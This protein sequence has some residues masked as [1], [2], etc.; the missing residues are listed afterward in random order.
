MN[1]KR[2]V[3]KSTRLAVACN[4]AVDIW[5]IIIG[6]VAKPAAASNDKK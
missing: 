6:S 1:L 3:R 4:G 2:S 5:P